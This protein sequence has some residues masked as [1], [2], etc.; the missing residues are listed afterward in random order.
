M[1]TTETPSHNPRTSYKLTISSRLYT[2][3]LGAV[4]LGA[5]IGVNRGARLASLRFLAENAH[6]TPHTQKGWYYY[7]KTKNYR[8]ILGA[9]RGATRDGLYLGT[10]TA[11]WVGLEEG[12]RAVGW[13]PVAMSGAGLGTAGIFCALYRL[14]WA[15]GRQIMLLGLV[16]GGSGDLVKNWIEK[17]R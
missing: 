7:H 11:G 3:P 2:V 16:G 17:R 13:G 1:N 12:L 14:G 6:R 15:R 8:V 9:L 5:V 10:V 4:L